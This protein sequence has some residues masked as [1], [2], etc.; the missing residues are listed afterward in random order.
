MKHPLHTAALVGVIAFPVVAFAQVFGLGV[1][2][3]LTIEHLVIAFST[4]G[5]VLML[6]DDYRPRH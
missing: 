1:P 5:I 2:S 4:L 6:A 3:W